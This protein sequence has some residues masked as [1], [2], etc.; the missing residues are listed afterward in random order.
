[1]LLAPLKP[2]AG[3][4]PT[5]PAA[6]KDVIAHRGYHD[7][8]KPYENTTEAYL[9]AIR[10]GVDV[11]ETDV[12][13]TKDGVLVLYH[14]A[15]IGFHLISHTN[16]ADLPKLPNGQPLSTL[17][18]LVDAVAGA[19]GHTRLLVET[20]ETGYE[21]EILATIRGKLRPDQVEFMSFNQDSVRALRR[22][23][24]DSR[25]G[26]LFTALLPDWDSLTWPIS[27]AAMVAKART[28]GVDFVAIDQHLAS[29]ARLDALAGAGIST[30]VWTVDDRADLQKYLADP[31]VG[32][33][34]TNTPDAAMAMRDTARARLG[35]PA[36]TGAQAATLW[37]R[38]AV[39]AA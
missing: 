35:I 14:D 31:R 27:G 10:L 9:R 33:I 15:W 11:M 32:G 23:A 24:P 18:G 28:L 13:R 6:P 38:T 21:A 37:R 20:K 39:L 7:G 16:Y 34:I 3:A 8:K 19:G 36:P 5:S 4:A 12:R 26:V 2:A 29:N 22:L 1:M 17:S 25:V 30:A